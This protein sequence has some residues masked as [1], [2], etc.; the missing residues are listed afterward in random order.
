MSS[1]IVLLL[2]IVTLIGLMLI[3]AACQTSAGESAQVVEDN[4]MVGVWIHTV[5]DNDLF[6]QFNSDDTW[7]VS[8]LINDLEKY[9]LMSGTFTYEDS[10]LTLNATPN[11][12]R[13]A[14]KIG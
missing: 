7:S 13:R 9:P 12:M 1:R 8:R 2:S 14:G 5:A 6:F 10:V 4:P 3:A 11:P